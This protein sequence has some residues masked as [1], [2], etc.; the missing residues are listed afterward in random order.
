MTD[1]KKLARTEEEKRAAENLECRQI[2]QE[3][4][5]HGVTQSQMMHII[6]LLALQLEDREVMVRISKAA[7]EP[8]EAVPSPVIGN[9]RILTQ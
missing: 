1:L 5:K 8:G 4:V 2:V 9:S 3:I 7:S 6:K